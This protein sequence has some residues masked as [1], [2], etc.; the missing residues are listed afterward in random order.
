MAIKAFFH[1]NVFL[2]FFLERNTDP[3]ILNHVFTLI[4]KKEMEGFT[5]ISILQT[6]IYYLDQTKGQIITREILVMILDNFQLLESNRMHVI[7]AIQS[8]QQDLE[9]AIHYFIALENQMDCI[10]TSD[11]KFLK[12]DS[13]I[14]PLLTPGNFIKRYKASFD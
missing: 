6:C 9:D 3:S 11:K 14:L 12:L 5:T 1:V 7:Q 8:G 4:D 10:I 13:A 2:D